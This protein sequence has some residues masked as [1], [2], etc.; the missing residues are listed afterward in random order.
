MIL[1]YA[2]TSTAD[3]EAGLE[4]QE[5]DLKAAGA[6]KLFAEKASSVSSR[7]ALE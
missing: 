2:R 5:R 7:K 6:E 4:A 1:G 3:Q